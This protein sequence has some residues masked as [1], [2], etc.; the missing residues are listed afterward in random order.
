[1]H[2]HMKTRTQL[3]YYPTT[4][5]SLFTRA[6]AAGS[7]RMGRHRN[8]HCCRRLCRLPLSPLRRSQLRPRLACCCCCC[9]C[10]RLALPPLLPPFLLLVAHRADTGGRQELG[11]ETPELNVAYLS[12]KGTRVQSLWPSIK[13]ITRKGRKE[14]GRRR[15]SQ[16]I[17][18]KATFRWKRRVCKP[19]A[20][21]PHPH[22]LLFFRKTARER[23]QEKLAR[24]PSPPRIYDTTQIDTHETTQKEVATGRLEDVDI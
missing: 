24:L 16:S 7:A 4:L 10:C 20:T 8:C 19:E 9:C 22:F 1:M 23:K 2:I 18:L 5:P 14:E 6:W 17:G 3:S 13:H 12:N 21:E 15:W 11:L